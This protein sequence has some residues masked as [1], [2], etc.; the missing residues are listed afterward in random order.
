MIDKMIRK[1]NKLVLGLMSILLPCALAACAQNEGKTTKVDKEVNSK[2]IKTMNIKDKKLLVAFFSRA[3]ENYNVGYIKKGNTQMVAEE[4]AKQ[5]GAD[6]FHIVTVKP[7]PAA[8]KAC[9]DQAQQELNDDA[10]P[11]IKGDVK[12]EDYDIIFLGYPNWW[13]APPMA[14][15]TFMEKHDWNGKTIV[16]FCTHEGS[17]LGSTVSDLKE[18]CKGAKFLTGLAIRG[19]DAHNSPD[20]VEAKVSQWIATINK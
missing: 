16:P 18:H 6:T 8:Y 20:L 1:M 17:G 2:N 5:T 3:D 7:Y 9:I 15:Y 19:T 13:G 4:I 14:V 10:R 12:V 11:E